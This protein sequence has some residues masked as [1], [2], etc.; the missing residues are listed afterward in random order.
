MRRS[1][2]RAFG[3]LVFLAVSGCATTDPAEERRMKQLA[4]TNTE[5][6]VQYLQRG[7]VSI[8]LGRVERALEVEPE[9][10][11]ANN[12]MGLIQ[13][14]L[15]KLD[16]ADRY[17]QRSVDANPN[18]SE[19]HNNYGVFLCAQGKVD[20]AVKQFELALENRLYTAR[21][22]AEVNAGRCLEKKG[23]AARAEKH[24]RNALAINPKYPDALYETA[25]LSF[26][27]GQIRSA[28][29]FLQRYFQ[30]GKPTADA[31]LLAV[32]VEGALGNKS[33]RDKFAAELRKTFP[34]SPQARALATIGKR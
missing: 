16:E 15:G 22:E 33:Q 3:L 2:L 34:N 30:A 31:L 20:D 14:R 21:A 28:Q 24:F 18:N 11:Q 7:Q 10:S 6:A 4:D 27:T 13:W 8:A 9:H 23:N 26:T 17:F 5:L 32:R 19:A 29:G 1:V 25:K 12:V